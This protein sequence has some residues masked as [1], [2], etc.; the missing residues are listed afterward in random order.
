MKGSIHVIAVSEESME[1]IQ[2]SELPLDYDFLFSTPQIPPY[3]KVDS[4][5][6]LL[7]ID[8]KMNIVFRNKGAGSLNTEENKSFL[9]NLIRE[10]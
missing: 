4:Y 5:P 3:Y 6:T 10:T 1:V 2:N 9:K 8:K 7:V